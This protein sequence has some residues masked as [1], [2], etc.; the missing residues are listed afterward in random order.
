MKDIQ[1]SLISVAEAAQILNCSE[2]FVRKLLRAGEL[3]GIRVKNTWLVKKDAFNPQKMELKKNKKNPEDQISR[4]N[5]DFNNKKLKT[6]SFF[7]G[8]G[9]LDI[10]LE[11]AGLDILMACEFDKASR[12]TLLNN[13]PDIGLIGDILNYSTDTIIEYAGL[14][15]KN[16]VDVIVGGPP[17]QAFST[18]GKRKGF[19]D[20]RGNVFLRYI[21]IILD[22]KPRYAVI[23]NVRGLLSSRINIETIEDCTLPPYAAD[24]AGSALWY[25]LDKLKKGGYTVSFNLY[26]SANFGSPQVRERVVV[27]CTLDKKPV[28]FLMP[29][30]SQNGEFGLKKWRTFRDAV[31]GLDSSDPEYV[32]IPEK[33]LKYFRLLKPGQNWRD[34]PEEIQ[35]EAM[36]KSF[37]LGGG[38]TGFYRR[39]SWEKPAPTLVTHPAMPATELA[40][41][42]EDRSISVQEYKR[43]Q[44][45]PDNWELLGTTVEKY[46]QIGNAVPIGLGRAIGT[47]LIKHAKGEEVIHPSGFSYSRYKNTCNKSWLMD[48]ERLVKMEKNMPKVSMPTLF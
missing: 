22:I 2:Q 33:R 4:L 20:A 28:P 39:L 35:P 17:C 21:D 11:Q 40:H 37:Y 16:Q 13:K 48:F 1:Q 24:I 31:A 29:T 10:G 32:K 18:A 43:V 5:I 34:L 23:E 15:D 38:K 19:D 46:R 7:S 44:E 25:V 6:L 27:I 41:P 45:F 42:E 3:P 14:T 47:A 8:A 9:G 12:S 30:H 36:G 26:N